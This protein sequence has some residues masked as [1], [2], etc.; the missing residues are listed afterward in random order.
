MPRV[1]ID[2]TLRQWP[3]GKSAVTLR[4][5]AGREVVLD[6]LISAHPHTYCLAELDAADSVI[7]IPGYLTDYHPDNAK[8]GAKRRPPPDPLVKL[9]KAG[10][11]VDAKTG[12]PVFVDAQGRVMKLA[13]SKQGADPVADVPPGVPAV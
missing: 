13:Q 11:I 8:D 4:D 2:I 3:T 7:E 12:E 9:S 6:G 10:A 1:F 5:K